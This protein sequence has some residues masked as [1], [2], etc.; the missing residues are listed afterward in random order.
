MG[1]PTTCRGQSPRNQRC[2]PPA[3]LLCCLQGQEILDLGPT[4]PAAGLGPQLD[5]QVHTTCAARAAALAWLATNGLCRV[6]LDA[7][8]SRGSRGDGV[9]GDG[10][11]L[12][13]RVWLLAPAFQRGLPEEVSEECPCCWR[14]V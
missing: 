3:A 13:L 1:L 5:A 6:E 10:G 8:Q 14:A 4:A 9:W 12:A 7:S 2:H 11:R